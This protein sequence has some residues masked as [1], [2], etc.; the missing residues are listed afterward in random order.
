MNKSGTLG[1]ERAG[2]AARAAS[3]TMYSSDESAYCPPLP[4]A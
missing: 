2:E 3:R 4:N 1:S